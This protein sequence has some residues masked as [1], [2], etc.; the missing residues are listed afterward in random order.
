MYLCL[1]LEM[2]KLFLEIERIFIIFRRKMLDFKLN[3]VIYI[4]CFFVPKDNKILFTDF[5]FILR[6]FNIYLTF[7]VNYFIIQPELCII[8]TDI[9]SRI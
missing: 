9:I 1:H 6:I 5:K 4:Y 2:K 3:Q 7:N 8:R